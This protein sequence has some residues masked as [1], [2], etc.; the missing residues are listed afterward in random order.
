[1][2]AREQVGQ[3]LVESLKYVLWDEQFSDLTF[4]CRD[5]PIRCHRVILAANSSIL[6]KLFLDEC[7][8]D[9]DDIQILLPD[10]NVK[11]VLILLSILY[12]GQINLFKSELNNLIELTKLLKLN[13]FL[14]AASQQTW[15]ERFT[16]SSKW[17]E[18]ISPKVNYQDGPLAIANQVSSQVHFD[19]GEKK[20]AWSCTNCGKGF[21]SQVELNRHTRLAHR[22]KGVK[23]S[24]WSYICN[25]D[26]NPCDDLAFPKI[27]SF[28]QHMINEHGVHPWKCEICSKRFKD[29]QNLQYHALAHSGERSFKCDL[30]PKSFTNPKALHCH[31]ELHT[32]RKFLCPH[33]GFKARSNANLYGHI[34]SKHQER[35]L[36]CLICYRAFASSN[37]LNHH[38][39]VHTG[40]T[41][42][43]CEICDAHFKRIH[44]LKAHIESR[45]H[46]DAM[47]NR[48]A[49]GETIPDHLDPAKRKPT[50][51]KR[52]PVILDNQKSSSQNTKDQA[53][54]SDAA[55]NMMVI[56]TEEN[57]NNTDKVFLVD[58]NDTVIEV[59]HMAQGKEIAA[60]VGP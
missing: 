2:N 52:V 51:S 1:M 13:N 34:R 26:Q 28:T 41:P 60:Q 15:T 54:S 17:Y 58:T 59:L 25:A 57:T 44:H 40:E 43:S 3:A 11:D 35:K 14:A 27:Q 49:L 24:I 32:G 23:D 8:R 29:R 48:I 37:N 50:V 22:K 5:G 45:T 12:C 16:G 42:Y 53:V 21:P 39:R 30:C 10:F 56:P 33:C 47:N 19:S 20:K 18:R 6:Q 46:W 7:Q 31:K 36:R 9:N 4:H 38:M 55:E